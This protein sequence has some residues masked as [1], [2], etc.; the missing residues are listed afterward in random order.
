MRG[1]GLG[2]CLTANFTV[3]G[4][5]CGH[6]QSHVLEMRACVRRSVHRAGH[7][8]KTCMHEHYYFKRFT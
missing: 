5:L 1:D 4:F 2:P 3:Y 6:I 8:V 7:A